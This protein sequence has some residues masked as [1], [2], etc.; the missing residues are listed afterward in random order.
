MPPP[1]VA[2]VAGLQEGK[3]SAASLSAKADKKEAPVKT[4]D[5]GAAKVEAA[6]DKKVAATTP[7]PNRWKWEG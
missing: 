3:G 2:P 6:G 5:S 7:N 4:G 1:T